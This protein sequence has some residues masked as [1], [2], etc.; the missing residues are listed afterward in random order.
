M[1]Q[2]AAGARDP[3]A[4]RDEAPGVDA[5]AD[6]RRAR[7]GDDVDLQAAGL[8]AP[9][10][11]VGVQSV[12]N[13]RLVVTVLHVLAQRQVQSW[14]IEPKHRLQMDFQELFANFP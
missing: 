1:L 6:R 7:T 12:G 10:R 8:G 4:G 14:K 11:R 5:R 2:A 9:E 3:S 13:G